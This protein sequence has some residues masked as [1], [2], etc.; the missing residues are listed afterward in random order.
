MTSSRVFTHRVHLLIQR[1]R[2]A[3]GSVEAIF[4]KEKQNEKSQKLQESHAG[5][6][7]RLNPKQWTC[8]NHVYLFWF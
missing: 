7:Q 5:A 3:N 6:F 2:V 4:P 8:F 1:Y